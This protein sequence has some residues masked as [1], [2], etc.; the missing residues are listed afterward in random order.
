MLH[1]IFTYTQYGFFNLYFFLCL[2]R[3]SRLFLLDFNIYGKVVSRLVWHCVSLF[4]TKDLLF[5]ED[6]GYA[7]S[8]RQVA[9]KIPSN[10]FSL[11]KIVRNISSVKVL[12]KTKLY[13]GVKTENVFKDVFFFKSILTLSLLSHVGTY[14]LHWGR[15]IM[16]Q[17]DVIEMLNLVIQIR[18]G[19]SISHN[20][21][22]ITANLY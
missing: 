19:S 17:R 9:T 2:L 13:F 1:W 21:R 20:P 14:I 4:S 16:L 3:S 7:T 5:F 11:A 12:D 22:Q 15:I 8:F 18:K 10:I 6:D